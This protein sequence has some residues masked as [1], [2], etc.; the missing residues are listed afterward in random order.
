MAIATY[1]PACQK[2]LLFYISRNNIKIAFY[3]NI[4]VIN[5]LLKK[6]LNRLYYIFKTYIS[7]YS[8]CYFYFEPFIST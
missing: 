1:M 7:Y 4:K 8:T 6:A 2:H 5:S 3:L